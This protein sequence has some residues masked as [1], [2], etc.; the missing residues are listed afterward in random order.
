MQSHTER[1]VQAKRALVQLLHETG[2][3]SHD[4]TLAELKRRKGISYE[5]ST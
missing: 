4:H 3:G 1:F 5:I 2:L